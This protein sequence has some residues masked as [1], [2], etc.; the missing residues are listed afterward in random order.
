MQKSPTRGCVAGLGSAGK[1][2]IGGLD[3][4]YGP[5]LRKGPNDV[6]STVIGPNGTFVN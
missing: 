3:I 1:I 4:R 6:G 2:D 5:N